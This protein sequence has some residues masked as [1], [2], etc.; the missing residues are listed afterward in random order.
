ML[1]EVGTEGLKFAKDVAAAT[2]AAM[3][4][5]WMGVVEVELLERWGVDLL[6]KSTC[7]LKLKLSNC[8]TLLYWL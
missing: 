7:L 3:H 6:A 8:Q 1:A 5:S 4:F 2:Q